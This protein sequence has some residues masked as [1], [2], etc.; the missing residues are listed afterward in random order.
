MSII[1]RLKD[2]AIALIAVGL[3]FL[4]NQFIAHLT[5]HALPY[6]IT[7]Y[8]AVLIV[9][10]ISGLWSGLLA[11]AATILVA[12]YFLIPPRG[13]FVFTDPAD[14][15]VV[16]IFFV[17]GVMVSV[18]TSRY[19]T[20]RYKLEDQVSIRTK[21]ITQSNQQLLKSQEQLAKF[22]RILWALNSSNQSMMHATDEHKILNDVCKNIV[23]NCG[24]SMVW[25]GFAQDDKEK[26][27]TPVAYSGF[28]Q[29]YL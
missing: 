26:T 5:G 8:P 11:T 9:A 17:M 16:I 21:E 12:D 2:Y 25:V 14:I 20:L 10:L 18:V 22:N 23:E 29:G 15:T 6:F 4:L 3:S 24:Y 7:F 19:R 27:I 28:E 13:L 1:N